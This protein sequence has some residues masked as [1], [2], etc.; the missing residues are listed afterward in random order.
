MKELKLEPISESRF[1][2]NESFVVIPAKTGIQSV[3]EVLDA[4]LLHAGMTATNNSI[5]DGF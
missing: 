5:S 1:I 4:R 2:M 3:Q